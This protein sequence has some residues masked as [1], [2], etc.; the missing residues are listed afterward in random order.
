M[1]ES[2]INSE[3]LSAD[4]RGRKTVPFAVFAVI[5]I[6][7]I[8]FLVLLIAAGCR[9][10]ARAKQNAAPE[11]EIAQTQTNSVPVESALLATNTPPITQVTEPVNAEPV[12][13]NAVPVKA[14][15]LNPRARGTRTLPSAGLPRGLKMAVKTHTV[16]QGET[17]AKIAKRY[18]MSVAAI[19]S[20]NK[21]KSDLLRVGQKL[22]VSSDRAQKKETMAAI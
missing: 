8:L 22:R 2:N 21:L 19:K 15:K 14:R 12:V 4:A 6:H 18:G 9:A 13:E 20:E 10:K 11:Q 16:Q 7:I 17:V 5:F 1:H 3:L